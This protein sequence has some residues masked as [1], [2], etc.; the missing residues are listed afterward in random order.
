VD[1]R[2]RRRAAQPAGGGGHAVT[3]GD[4][5]PGASAEGP[6]LE[7]A[8]ETERLVA[9]EGPVS[10]AG[11]AGQQTLLAI[12]QHLRQELLK[13]VDVMTQVAEG[14]TSAAEARSY[15][16]LMTMRQNYWTLGAFCAAYCRVLSVHHAIEDQHM[17]A[18]VVAAD[19]SPAPV[20]AH[21]QD[22]ENQ[23]REPI[24]RLAIPI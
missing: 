22:E 24:G 14:Q 15:L 20:L 9:S 3:S 10:A 12:H 16:N 17:F 18:G 2:R 6:V 7:A 19:R 23:L 21:L 4:D 5:R 13:L 1:R 8:R 11:R